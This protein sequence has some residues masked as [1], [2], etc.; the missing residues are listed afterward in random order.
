MAVQP[1]LDWY[2]SISKQHGL[3]PRCPFA[4]VYRCPR[5]YQSL[6]LLGEAGSTKIN[7]EEDGRLKEGWQRTDVW[8]ITDEQATSISGPGDES[9]HFSHFCPEVLFDRFG[10]FTDELHKY[11]DDIDASIIHKELS[12]EGALPDD[13]R[14]SWNFANPLHYTE[15]ALYSLLKAGKV[16]NAPIPTFPNIG[17]PDSITIQKVLAIEDDGYTAQDI[18]DLIIHMYE[19]PEIRTFEFYSQVGNPYLA[20]AI[21]DYKISS[22]TVEAHYYK[23]PDH[24]LDFIKIHKDSAESD[25]EKHLISTSPMYFKRVIALTDRQKRIMDEQ[26][27][28]MKEHKKIQ[29]GEIP[30]EPPKILR[31]VEW[32][33]FHGRR[34]WKKHP[35]KAI[36]AILLVVVPIVFTISLHTST[37]IGWFKSSHK[38]VS[39]ESQETTPKSAPTIITSA[40]SA[41]TVQLAPKNSL[42]KKPRDVSQAQKETLIVSKKQFK[43]MQGLDDVSKVVPGY[44][45]LTA[46]PSSGLYSYACALTGDNFNTNYVASVRIAG[47]EGAGVLE[48]QGRGV[49]FAVDAFSK[50]YFVYE[51]E[52]NWTTWREL[53]VGREPNINTL[54]LDQNKRTVTVFLNGDYV[55]TFTKLK[56]SEPGPIGICFKANPQTGGRIQFQKLSIWEL[57]N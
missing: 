34:Y 55:T 54:I 57:R 27:K 49:W 9:K 43:N 7:P 29:N 44:F 37:I 50:L 33:W 16:K 38:I 45:E 2:V 26:Q 52:E 12:K 10:L 51:S 22:D 3:S 35:Y 46:S 28:Q 18:E 1:N 13:W 40:S 14:W 32:V 41:P 48:L 6:S 19:H 24:E 25:W 8:P 36:F 31:N 21:N 15:C 4:S 53:K 23:H 47:L 11:A 56:E 17:I 42:E 5:F 30:P 20:K 39:T